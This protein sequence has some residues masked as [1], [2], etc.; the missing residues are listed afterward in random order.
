MPRRRPRRPGPRRR[1]PR[2]PRPARAAAHL[3]VLGARSVQ[4]PSS[5]SR[6]I[7]TARLPPPRP[8]P[9]HVT[10]ASAD[11]VSETL[12]LPDQV[13]NEVEFSVVLDAEHAIL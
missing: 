4:P 1:A 12:V 6:A 10:P 11:L 9:D 5:S 3:G 8:G 13:N 7:A 2:R